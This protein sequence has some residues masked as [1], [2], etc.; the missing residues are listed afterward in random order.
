MIRRGKAQ[1][2]RE[3]P[4]PVEMQNVKCPL[5]LLLTKK[6]YC[7]VL[8]CIICVCQQTVVKHT[9]IV[10]RQNLFSGS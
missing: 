10:R 6:Y 1:V 3:K 2:L 8:Y 9:N 7:I 5:L 4:L